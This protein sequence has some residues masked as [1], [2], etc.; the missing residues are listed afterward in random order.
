[1]VPLG[2]NGIVINVPNVVLDL[3]GVKIRGPGTCASNRRGL[4]V[5][6]AVLQ[7]PR[8]ADLQGAASLGGDPYGGAPGRGEA[9][10]SRAPSVR[11]F[12]VLPTAL[13]SGWIDGRFAGVP[14][15]APGGARSAGCCR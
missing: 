6:E 1:M 3:G 4:G 9:A 13:R 12:G 7:S 15:D 8:A 11:N 10:N 2:S 14:G 5:R